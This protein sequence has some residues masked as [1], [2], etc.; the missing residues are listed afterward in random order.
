MSLMSLPTPMKTPV[1]TDKILQMNPEEFLS[2]NEAIS[3]KN[4]EELSPSTPSRKELPEFLPK[5][6]IVQP[7]HVAPNF[8]NSASIQLPMLQGK[9]WAEWQ[10]RMIDYLEY[11]GLHI[12]L[13]DHQSL[14]GAT[15]LTTYA[16]VH[17]AAIFVIKSHIDFAV[18]SATNPLIARKGSLFE[19]MGELRRLYASRNPAVIPNLW[20]TLRSE[21]MKPHSDLRTHI[22][23][24]NML[25]GQ[26]IEA[27]EQVLPATF[28]AILLRSLPSEY[29]YAVTVQQQSMF[30]FPDTSVTEVEEFL[31]SQE[32]K[33]PKPAASVAM[34]ATSG[35]ICC[36]LKIL[37]IGY[38]GKK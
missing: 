7:H 29:D 2:L 14:V 17:S 5:N 11:K 13:E 21:R 4:A 10:H 19:L 28:I 34:S 8:A 23:R 36:K 27:G 31:Y 1:T 18:L 6:A 37:L 33:I 22:S 32:L 16:N 25:R 35:P 20:E 26:V 9:N 30:R 38:I 15:Q 3:E 12:A 24:L